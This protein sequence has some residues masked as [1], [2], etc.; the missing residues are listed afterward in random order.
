MSK[1]YYYFAYGMNTNLDGMKDRCPTA[2]NLGAAI[3]PNHYFRFA[4]HADVVSRKF[5]EVDGVLWAITQEDLDSLDRL[6]GYPVYYDRKIVK[7]KHNGRT[8][9]AITYFMQPGYEDNEPA[10]YYL[11]CVT[12]GYAENDVPLGQ[13]FEALQDKSVAQK[14]H[15]FG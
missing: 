7:V 4:I 15:F 5:S 13:I 9:R 6:E 2:T 10:Q 8:V 12:K 11:D 14:Q 3:L 1:R